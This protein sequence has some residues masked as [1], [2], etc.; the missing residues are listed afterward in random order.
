MKLLI[1]IQKCF[2]ICQPSVYITQIY[3]FK[4]PMSFNTF[5]DISIPILLLS[6]KRLL[7]STPLLS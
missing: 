4:R 5:F 1:L 7:R 3:S 6:T 2:F